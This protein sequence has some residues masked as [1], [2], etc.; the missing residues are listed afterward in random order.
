M[1]TEL[2]KPKTI[3][4]TFT[5]VFCLV[6]LIIVSTASSSTYADSQ[7][8]GL[9]DSQLNMFAQNDIL[10]YDPGE[11]VDSGG[12]SSVCGN[13][14]KEKYWS[15]LSKYIDDPIK[16]AGVMGN[17]AAE[18]NFQ[19]VLWEYSIT[20]SDGT[21]THSWNSIYGGDLDGS[22]GVG[23]FGI[24]SGLS[25]YLHAVNENNPDMIKY[26]KDSVKYSVGATHPG[27][28]ID[29][30]HPTWGDVLLEKIGEEDFG[31]L[32]EF[33]VKYAM[34]DFNPS[35]TKEYLDQK[36]SNPSD[37][38]YWW[39]DQWERPAYRNSEAREK[40]AEEAYDKFKNFKCGSS[41]SSGSSKSSSSKNTCAKLGELRKEM[42]NKASQADKE[43]FMKTV[44]EEDHSIAGVEGYMNQIISKHGS[45]GTLHDWLTGQCEKYRP[46]S[47]SCTGSHKITKEE[48]SWIDDALAG[49]NN[50]KFAI[51]NATGGSGVGAGKIVCVWNGNK[52]RDDVDYDKEDGKG[53]CSVYSPSANFGECWGLEGEDD[54]AKDMEKNCASSGCSTGKFVWYAQ[55][56]E[57]W[58]S[59]KY[60]VDGVTST[61]GEDGC[62]PTAFAMLANILLPKEI[63]PRDTIKVAA[64][65]KSIIPGAGSIGSMLTKNLAEHYGLEWKKLN[66]SSPKASM[67]DITKHLKEGW[68]IMTAGQG[69]TP[70]TSGG[71]YVGIRGITDDGKWLLADSGHNE[72][73]SK[74]SWNPK[75]VVS[76]GMNPDN[77]YAIRSS[78]SGA[79]CDSVCSGDNETTGTD[80][81][82]SVEEAQK[83]VIKEY[84]D[85]SS[86]KLGSSYGLLLPP[87]K[88]YHDNCVAFS[89]WFINTYTKISYSNPPNGNELVDDFYQKNKKKYPD[90]KITN[91]P[92]VY[93]VASWSVAVPAASSGNHTGIVV[94]IDEEKKKILIAEAGWNQPSFTGVH[95]YDLEPFK[96]SGKKYINLNKYL[97]SNTGL[98]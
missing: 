83:V 49:S 85:M 87:S 93:S 42:W 22:K 4:W 51:G 54:W 46:A 70:Y 92:S 73:V 81:F 90:L 36:F 7:N 20:N 35:R 17:L 76:A 29:D 78:S 5:R 53:K 43:S 18:G 94:G 30:K 19:P 2:T 28:G 14:A 31:K 59:V 15:A 63:T 55:F 8:Q 40:A 38:A 6:S 3:F 25:S 95:E 41:S 69:S 11:C 1:N 26:F 48:Q 23:A 97:K 86:N 88:D 44:S 60:T 67:D 80:G 24:T 82:T 84:K 71:H 45:D 13:T 74:Q 57:P 47:S 37:A 68:L 58:A 16:V 34:E 65:T 61:I 39:M 50:I 21:L 79:N 66:S 91:E 12:S 32:V 77:V 89:T 10:F 62:G 9:S 75:D 52:C 98:K 56:L 72:E 33:E 96:G 27:V 64:D